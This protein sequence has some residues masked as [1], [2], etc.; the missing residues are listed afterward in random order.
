MRTCTQCGA[1][2]DRTSSWCN[3]CRAAGMRKYRATPQG[4]EA[5]RRLE[6]QRVV[7]PERIEQGKRLR[8]EYA[9][10]EKG[11]QVLRAATKR[12]QTTHKEKI[13]QAERN[14]RKSNPVFKMAANLRRRLRGVLGARNPMTPGR[15]FVF[16]GCSFATFKQ[17]VENQFTE[18]MCWEN[19]GD[20]HLDHKIPLSSAQSVDEVRK[21]N[22]FTNIQPMWATYNRLKQNML[23]EEW[24]AYVQQ[25]QIDVTVPVPA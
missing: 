19:Y 1:E 23:P 9:Q 18:G 5:T 25:H 8:K 17:H 15:M 3:P 7:T 4:K 6:Q 10:T 13:L 22:H 12:Y 11:R 20:W 24:A 16:L 21:L 2:H 14:R